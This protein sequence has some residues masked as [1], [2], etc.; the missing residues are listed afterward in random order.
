MATD[1]DERM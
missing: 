1:L